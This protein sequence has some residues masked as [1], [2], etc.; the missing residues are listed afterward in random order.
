MT[1]IQDEPI[2]DGGHLSWYATMVIENELENELA[3]AGDAL[4]ESSLQ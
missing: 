2:D 1:V 4:S 3:K